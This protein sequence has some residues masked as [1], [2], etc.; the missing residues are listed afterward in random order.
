VC[1]PAPR[2]ARFEQLRRERVKRW[3][4]KEGA[5]ERG[6]GPG[7]EVDPRLVLPPIMRQ[8]ARKNSLAWMV[9]YRIDWNGKVA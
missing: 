2:S 8:I 5:T 7:R 9:D 4:R 1:R 3:W 6:A